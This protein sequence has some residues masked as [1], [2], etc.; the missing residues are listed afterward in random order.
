[1]LVVIVITDRSFVPN[2]CVIGLLVRARVDG[3][4]VGEGDINDA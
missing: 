4:T 2:D 1:M 3:P